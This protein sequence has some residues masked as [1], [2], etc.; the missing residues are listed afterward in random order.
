MDDKDARQFLRYVQEYV[1]DHGDVTTLQD[2]A[3]DLA[4]SIEP[5]NEDDQ[6]QIMLIYG[7]IEE[8]LE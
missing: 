6:E 1:R 4:L 2:L 5:M 7:D 8:M 3:E